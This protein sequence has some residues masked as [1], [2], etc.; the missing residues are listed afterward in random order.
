MGYNMHMSDVRMRAAS[1]SR[2]RLGNPSARQPMPGGP[3]PGMPGGPPPGS[4]AMTVPPGQHS[5]MGGNMPMMPNQ[6]MRPQVRSQVRVRNE[7]LLHSM[8]AKL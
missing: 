5:P 3:P 1:Q 7:Y 8:K 2:Y 4:Q 6:G